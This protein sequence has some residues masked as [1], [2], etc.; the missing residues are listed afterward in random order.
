[1]TVQARFVHVNLIAQDWRKL[2][3]FY[4]QVF[5]CTPV[6]PERNLSGRWLEDGTGVHRSKVCTCD[7]PVLANRARRLKYSSTITNWNGRNLRSID[8][9]LP[10]SPSQLMTSQPPEMQ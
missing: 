2:A 9:D 4:Q 3:E 10:T 8:L 7:F 6:P 1:M 5:G